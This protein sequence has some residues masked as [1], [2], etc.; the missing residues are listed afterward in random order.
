MKEKKYSFRIRES[1]QDIEEILSNLGASER[2]DFI[3][4]A[5]R[6]YAG[7]KD[8]LDDIDKKLDCILKKIET[9]S[10]NLSVSPSVSLS[11]DEESQKTNETE[12]LLIES[13]IDILS[14]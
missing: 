5:V 1:D 12:K 7:Y 13:V 3:R 4:N 10:E 14:L 2:S 11:N 8:R 9:K 6:F